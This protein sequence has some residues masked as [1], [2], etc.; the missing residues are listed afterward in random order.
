MLPGLVMLIPNFENMVKAGLVDTYLGLILPA[1][2]SAG[3]G[4]AG[5][6]S[7]TGSIRAFNLTVDS[8]TIDGPTASFDGTIGGMF[9]EPD[10]DGLMF[11]FGGWLT[12]AGVAVSVTVAPSA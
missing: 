7:L 9:A 10:R 11:S 3:T 2:F 8:L 12:P 5:A 4:I 1:S 6:T